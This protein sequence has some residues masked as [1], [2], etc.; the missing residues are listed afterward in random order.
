MNLPILNT[1]DFLMNASGYVDDGNK[2]G[3]NSVRGYEFI[4]RT[5]EI[6]LIF[7]IYYKSLL[8][9]K[10]NNSIMLRYIFLLM[11]LVLFLLSF[12][13]LYE[14]YSIAF[15]LFSLFIIYF[16]ILNKNKKDYLLLMILFLF[17]LRFILLNIV[18]YGK[19]FT[20][21]YNTILPNHSKKIEMTFKPFYYSTFFLLD[22]KTFGYSNNYILKESTR[23][24]EYLQRNKKS[25]ILKNQQGN[26]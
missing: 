12:K 2:W 15:F 20:T 22:I 14:R 3:Q 26:L 7:F 24:R 21:E 4:L 23:G 25:S 16:S 6:I 8:L 13:S 17:F 18:W 19:I 11:G 10:I 1:I 5:I 9:L